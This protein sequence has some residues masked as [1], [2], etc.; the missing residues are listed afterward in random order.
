M[1]P[2]YAFFLSH[3][4]IDLDRMKLILEVWDIQ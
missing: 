1:L 4:N 2:T 3:A